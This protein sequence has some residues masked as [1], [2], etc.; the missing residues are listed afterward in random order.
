MRTQTQPISV[1]VVDP[2]PQERAIL[3]KILASRCSVLHANTLA[4][5]THLLASQHPAVIIVERDLPDG[6]GLTIVQ[7]VRNDPHLHDVSIACVTQR[8]GVRDK[9]A[10]FRAGADDYIIKPV[11]PDVFLQRILLL[12]R[13]RRLIS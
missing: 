12:T 4:E 11:N 7:Q 13:M 9:I 6:D 3:A 10:G 1:L 2:D 8:A 5:A